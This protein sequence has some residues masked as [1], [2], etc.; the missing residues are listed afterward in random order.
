[1]ARKSPGH[2][3]L[4]GLLVTGLIVIAPVGVTAFV[5]WWLFQ[6]LDGLVGQFFQP[7]LQEALGFH[8]P[9][10]GLLALLLLLLGTGWVA[11]RAIG[12]RIFRYAD[13]LFERFPLTRGVYGASSR[14]VRTVFE[15]ERRPF[16]QVALFEYPSD[17]RWAIGFVASSGPAFASDAIDEDVVT[18]FMPTTPNPTSGFLVVVPRR[19]VRPLDM[20]V[21]EAFT[22]ILSVGTVSPERAEAI[23]RE[24][25]LDRPPATGQGP[26]AGAPEGAA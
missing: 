21:E 6:L 7:H 12:T 22:F 3:S 9:G 23:V 18:I 13:R 8:V 15:R 16:R 17:E 11:E 10:L 14:I 2:M 1:M 5:L 25:G 26:A 24:H 4:K 20:S 19:K